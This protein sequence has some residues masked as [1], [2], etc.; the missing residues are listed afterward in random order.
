M[1]ALELIFLP[2]VCSNPMVGFDVIFFLR[3]HDTD[4]EVNS[5]SYLNIQTSESGKL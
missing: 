2:S 1:W 3:W 5:D 4:I